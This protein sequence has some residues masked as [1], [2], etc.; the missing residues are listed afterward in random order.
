MPVKYAPL[1]VIHAKRNGRNTAQ[2]DH[3]F[4]IPERHEK[5]NEN[6][7]VENPSI[8][9][10]YTF[11]LPKKKT[12]N[13]IYKENEREYSILDTKHFGQIIYMEVGAMLIG[14]I[15]NHDLDTFKR[16]DEKGYFLPGGSTVVVIANNIKVDK[17]IL[18]NSKNNIET[19][20]EV[21]EKVGEKLC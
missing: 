6:T 11:S 8:Y 10:V 5:K 16:G 18:N 1:S 9:I 13:K 20:V 12:E 21:G 3:S 7:I 15:I 14:K 17:D 2:T 19:L 4:L